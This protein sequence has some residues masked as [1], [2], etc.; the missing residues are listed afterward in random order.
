[1]LL[2]ALAQLS[3][4]RAVIAGGHPAEPDLDRLRGLAR[5]L[6]VADRVTFTGMIPRKD[7]PAL[8]ADADVLA[9]PYF[10]TPVIERYSSP[11][12]LFEYMA[13]G[14]PIVASNLASVRE[15]LKDG[16]NARL[17]PPADPAALAAVI[18]TVFDDRAFAERIAR[19]AFEDVG[20]Y[21]WDERAAAL[22]AL[23]NRV[24]ARS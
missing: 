18:R 5:Q 1:V 20:A 17:V 22:E 4:T 19:R 24:V 13:A 6:G 7:V 11:L 15:V 21:S 23:F 14:R 2:Q 12:K 10:S 3:D 8:L 16:V 9:M